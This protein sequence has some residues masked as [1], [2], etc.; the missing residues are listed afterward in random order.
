MREVKLKYFNTFTVIRDLVYNLWVILLAAVVGFCS[1]QIY[2]GV[3]VKNLYTSSMTISVN[4]SGYTSEATVLS[5]AR[6]IQITQA[7]EEVLGSQPL[8]DIVEAEIDDNVTG[9]I[10]ATQMEE[11]NLITL[12]VTD[13]TPEKAYKTLLA[14]YESY[15]ILTDAAF[16]NVIIN[17]ISNPNMPSTWS[18]RMQIIYTSLFYGLVGALICAAIIVVISYFRDTVKNV[19]DVEDL[20][21]TKLFGMACHINKRKSKIKKSKDGILLTNPLISAEFSDNFRS[22]AIKLES[23]RKTKRI[24][25]VALTSILENEGKTTVTVNLA[26]ALAELGTR[27]LIVDADFKRPAVYKFFDKREATAEHEFNAYVKG[28]LSDPLSLI[29]KDHR[30]GVYLACGKKARKNSSELISSKAFKKAL[31]IYENEFDIVLV[32][33]PP[34]GLAIDAEIMSEITTKMLFVVR[35]DFAVVPAIND[36]LANVDNEH[37]LGCIFNDVTV[38]DGTWGFLKADYS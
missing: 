14:V 6:V 7:F 36:Y 21:D 12:S 30:T 9:V 20:L 23:L 18:N 3:F 37:I 27:V 28:E 34:C 29:R 5:L 2:H 17:V 22:M 26:I 38:L 31:E 10:T 8:V 15:P 32:D 24:K 1:C 11:T 33:T 19:T 16:N 25:S 13:N 4:L 35:Q